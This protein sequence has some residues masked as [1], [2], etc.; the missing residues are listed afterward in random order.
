M[1]KKIIALLILATLITSCTN[2]P[3][4]EK[5]VKKQFTTY[6]V[7]TGNLSNIWKFVGYTTGQKEVMLATKVPG[8]I[9]YLAKN[10]WDKVYAW[11]VLAR[12][13]ST[14]A[15]TWYSTANSIVN[16]LYNLRNQTAKAYDWQI[17]SLKAK[18]KQAEI[19]VK[20]METW[21]KDTKEI[22]TSQL[23]TA[24]TGLEQ[25][26]LWLETAQ[27]NLEETKKSLEVKYQNILDWGKTAITQSIILDR[28]IIDFADKLLWMTEDNKRYNDR[29]ESF[30]WAKNSRQLKE[31]KLIFL[32]AKKEVDKYNEYYKKNIENKDNIWEDKIVEWL[33]IAEKTAEKQKELLKWLY[34]VMENSIPSVSFPLSVINEYKKNISQF[35]SQVESS[36]LTV[37]W[38]YIVWIK[39]TLQN[40][41]DFEASKQ[42]AITLLEKQVELAK[43]SLDTAQKKYEQYLNMGN[44]KINE[45][46]TKKDIALEQLQ[47]AKAWLKALIAKKEASLRE[48]DAKIAEALWGKKKANVMINNWIVVSN[49]NWIVTQKM[50]EVG[51][52]INAWMPIYMVSDNSV[53]KVKTSI[54]YNFYKNLKLGDKVNIAIEWVN[55]AVIAKV[56]MLS[57]KANPFTKKYDIE[58]KIN[59]KDYKYPNWAMAIIILK[60]KDNKNKVGNAIIPVN[61]IVSKFWVPAVY[62]IEKNKAVLKNI[63]IIKLW[64]T[65]AEVTWI[66][67]L[68]KIIVDWKE[69]IY[70]GEILEK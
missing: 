64:Q 53:L 59:N 58:V 7:T 30:L 29:F 17:E 47:E 15:K 69:N 61:S 42:K 55:K 37:S 12:L 34:D 35:G 26:K 1:V 14:E 62:V 45:V 52:V 27:K 51:Q 46:K 66:K 67:S 49:I 54:P 13:D 5:K 44:W 48:I 19:W 6:T 40:L 11:E 39:W 16:S 18:I 20:W 8:R 2:N 25:A 32:D 9:V 43:A 41:K 50:A 65:K 60:Q 38:N 3:E 24:K 68:D 63:K 36:L 70:D 22:T 21:L 4:K 10:V 28:N 31:T 57:K 56:S 33:K 23:E